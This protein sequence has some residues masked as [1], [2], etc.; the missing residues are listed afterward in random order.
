MV[1]TPPSASRVV[2]SNDGSL[3]RADLLQAAFRALEGARILDERA[4]NRGTDDRG[5]SLLERLDAHREILARRAANVAL[6]PVHSAEELRELRDA[7]HNLVAVH[8]W[9]ARGLGLVGQLS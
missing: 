1:Q 5:S 3:V 8:G 4:S 7:A 2:L 9:V 6:A